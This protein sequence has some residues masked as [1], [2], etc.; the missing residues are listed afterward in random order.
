MVILITFILIQLLTLPLGTLFHFY[1]PAWNQITWPPMVLLFAVMVVGILIASLQPAFSVWT[2]TTQKILGHRKSTQRQS[3]F[4]QI[5]T[6]FQFVGAIVLIVRFFSISKQVDLIMNDS[7]GIDRDHVVVVDLPL[8]E[9]LDLS[10]DAT[11]QVEVSSLK[12]LLLSTSDVEDIGLK[13]SSFSLL[14]SRYSRQHT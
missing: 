1:L 12:K 6:V 11:Y 5:T 7:W 10:T 13:P 9:G 14:G 4:V 3:T 8:R 2:M